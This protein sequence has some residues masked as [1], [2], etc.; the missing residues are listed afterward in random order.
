MTHDHSTPKSLRAAI[1]GETKKFLTGLKSG[2]SEEE[3]VTMLVVIRQ[4]E[5]EL[6]NRE[7]S[8]LAPEI[9]KLL[10]RR[11]E[12]RRKKDIDDNLIIN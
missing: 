3:L 2:V 7:G 9:W 4:L 8:M 10:Y 6:L 5:G 11:I 1:I 12:A